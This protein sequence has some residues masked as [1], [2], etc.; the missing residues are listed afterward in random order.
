LRITFQM[1]TAYETILEL[2]GI[3]FAPMIRKQAK[4]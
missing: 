4:P 1:S 2:P 3:E